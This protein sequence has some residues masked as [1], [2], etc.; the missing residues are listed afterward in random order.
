MTKIFYSKT[1]PLKQNHHPPVSLE[2]FI[3]IVY[4]N[5]VSYVA[6]FRSATKI[7][8][9]FYLFILLIYFIYFGIR[10]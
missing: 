8:S 2:I 5:R 7:Q 9:A 3:F 10:L 4:C 1:Y 6:T